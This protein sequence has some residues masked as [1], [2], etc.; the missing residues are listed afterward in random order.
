MKL[1]LQCIFNIIDNVDFDVLSLTLNELLKMR[2]KN[3]G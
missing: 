1:T 2:Y 3:I